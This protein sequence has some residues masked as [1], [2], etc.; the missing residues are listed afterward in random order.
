MTHILIKRSCLVTVVFSLLVLSACGSTPVCTN[1]SGPCIGKFPSYNQIKVG[2]FPTAKLHAGE[3]VQV[4]FPVQY[5]EVPTGTAL[6]WSWIGRDTPGKGDYII[7]H[8]GNDI[9]FLVTQNPFMPNADGTVTFSVTAAAG[10]V[11]GQYTENGT[12]DWIYLGRADVS[13]GPVGIPV[14]VTI[15]PR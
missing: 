13:A 6:K 3:T 14:S 8:L 7:G 9:T 4:S 12:Q 10:A 2:T 5:D 1:Y 11:P 15:L